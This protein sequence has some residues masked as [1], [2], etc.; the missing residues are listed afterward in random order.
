MI[1]RILCAVLVLSLICTTAYAQKPG[2]PPVATQS[3]EVKDGQIIDGIKFPA[4][5]KVTMTQGDIIYYAWPSEDFEISGVKV[6]KGT[7]IMLW[8]NG[9]LQQLWALEGQKI[10]DLTLKQG[11]WVGFKEN[12]QLDSILYSSPEIV[13]GLNIIQFALFYDNGKFKQIV[14]ADD[15]QVGPCMFKSNELRFHPNEQVMA[16]ILADACELQARDRDNNVKEETF[17]AGT[18][19]YFTE[20]GV[21]VGAFGPDAGPTKYGQEVEPEGM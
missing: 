17:S 2:R 16:G 8:E 9:Q 20:D 10:L 3:I 21:L 5:S 15:Q 7:Q 11:T 18:R 1:N 14:L 13:R 4:G 12:G 6:L 19:V